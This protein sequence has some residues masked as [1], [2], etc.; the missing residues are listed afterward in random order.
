MS[1]TRVERLQ[2]QLKVEISDILRKQVKDPR[3]GF[4]SITGVEMSKDFGHV[5]VFVSVMGDDMAKAQSMAGLDKAGG[6]I[7]T[8]VG[9]RI[10]LRHTPEIL[11][12]LDDSIE[13]GAH[14]LELLSKLKAEEGQKA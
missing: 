10:R 3:I 4:V 9:A 2:E 13:H 1:S 12:R 8:E 7:R 5:K 14:I 11:F 6:F